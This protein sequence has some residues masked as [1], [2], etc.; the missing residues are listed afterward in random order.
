MRRWEP[1]LKEWLPEIIGSVVLI[2]ILVATILI[3]LHIAAIERELIAQQESNQRTLAAHALL[4]KRVEADEAKVCL[5]AKAS[6]D[7][8]II[9]IVCP[10]GKS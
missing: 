5:A 3:T 1:I 9:T 4:L 6:G 2:W 10:G 8:K 7:Q